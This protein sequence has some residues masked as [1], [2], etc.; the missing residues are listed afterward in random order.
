MGEAE[1]LLK[2]YAAMPVPRYTSYP[3]PRNFPWRWAPR[4]GT[5]AAPCRWRPAGLGLSARALL[6]ATSATIAAARQ[7]LSPRQ[8]DRQLPRRLGGRDR[9]RG[10][11]RPP[12]SSRPHPLGRRHASSLGAEGLASV[13]AVL[14]LFRDLARCRARDRARS[15]WWMHRSPQPWLRSASTRQPRRAGHRSLVQAAIGRIQPEERGGG[16]LRRP[17]GGRDRR[18]QCRS[19]LWPAAADGKIAAADLRQGGALRP[20]RGGLLWLCDMPHRRANQKR[21]NADS[22]PAWTT[23]SNRPRRW[24]RR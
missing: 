20:A 22:L 3:P 9:H 12:G 6:A 13:M 2:H 11:L 5:V 19:D 4:A 1:D 23:A 21:I 8:R 16:R 24:P 18:D 7:G 10:G 14:A 17:E 15:G